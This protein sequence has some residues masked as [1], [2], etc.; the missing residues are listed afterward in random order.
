MQPISTP[1]RLCRLHWLNKYSF[2]TCPCF[3]GYVNLCHF[4]CFVYTTL[5]FSV[6][7]MYNSTAMSIGLYK[8]LLHIGV[9]VLVTWTQCGGVKHHIVW[10]DDNT[11]PLIT[12]YICSIRVI[13][14]MFIPDEYQPLQPPINWLTTVHCCRLIDWLIKCNLWDRTTFAELR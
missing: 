7:Q 1:G 4:Y 3:L 11:C 14:I 6:R 12:I 8:V 10:C 5:P 13:P 9:F 2:L